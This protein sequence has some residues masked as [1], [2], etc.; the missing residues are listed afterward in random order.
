LA[1]QKRLR[2]TAKTA[3][4]TL[5]AF[6][7]ALMADFAAKLDLLQRNIN[8]TPITLADIPSHLRQRYV[9]KSGRYLLQIFSR[10]NIW[11]REPMREFVTQ[12]QT[13]DADITGS[14]VIAFYS[15]R[16]MLRGYTRGGLY[17]LLV[18]IGIIVILFRRLK[19]TLL[20]IIPM[21]V[22]GLWTMACMAIFDLSLN[23]ANLII[24]P[25]FIGIAVDD[26]IHLVHRMLES[27]EDA[28]SP[29]ARST[30]KAIVLTSL[31]SIVGFGSLMIAG[32]AGVFSLG[33]I[34]ATAVGCA[35][36]A[37]LVVLP[38]ILHLFATASVSSSP[39]LASTDL[40][41]S[42]RF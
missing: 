12:L 29:L 10:H 19:P 39:P 8:P 38:L 4:A 23:M 37:T 28:T 25:L 13:V 22:G 31:T 6:Q 20:A 1:L 18:I 30:G 42:S 14:P 24:L 34:A 41:V 33:V 17:A 21:L 40:D 26:G 11:E 27:P 3:H 2:A 5:E 35:L 32:H 16:Q 15:I 7:G 36:I 9:S